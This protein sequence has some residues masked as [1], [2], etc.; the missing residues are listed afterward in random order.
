MDAITSSTYQGLG[1]IATLAY[2]HRKMGDHPTDPHRTALT[3]QARTSIYIK[4]AIKQPSKQ[5][6]CNTIRQTNNP[7]C[8]K[9]NL[10][11]LIEGPGLNVCP[12]DPTQN[13]QTTTTTTTTT[14]TYI[15][16][17]IYIYIRLRTNVVTAVSVILTPSVPKTLRPLPKTSPS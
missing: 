11:E 12:S 8:F 1:T 3:Q 5:P 13:Q 7:Q 16:I 2:T 10:Y 4:Q 15:Y 9:F 6:T 17:Y 14:T